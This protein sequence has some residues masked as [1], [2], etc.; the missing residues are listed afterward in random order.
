MCVR[1]P[2]GHDARRPGEL[3]ITRPAAFLSEFWG[4]R[5]LGEDCEQKVIESLLEAEV[6]KTVEEEIRNKVDS[7]MRQELQRLK[8]VLFFCSHL[9]LFFVFFWRSKERTR[10]KVNKNGTMNEDQLKD[11]VFRLRLL[12]NNHFKAKFSETK[13]LSIGFI[14]V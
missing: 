3:E 4:W 8:E 12:R 14:H 2:R 6:R 7:L 10:I 9:V 5:D 1:Q 11:V 13:H